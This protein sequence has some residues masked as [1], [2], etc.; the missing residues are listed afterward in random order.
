MVTFS[1]KG[2]TQLFSG[3]NHFLS[4]LRVGQPMKGQKAVD[5]V[6]CGPAR[7][8]PRVFLLPFVL[9]ATFVS[10]PSHLHVYAQT[11]EETHLYLCKLARN[12]RNVVVSGISTNQITLFNR[13][14]RKKQISWQFLPFL[15]LLTQA[16]DHSVTVFVFD[17]AGK[18][19]EE[20]LL[21]LGFLRRIR[22]HFSLGRYNNM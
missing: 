14:D 17:F 16:D 3:I 18:S 2:R 1:A 12:A 20:V 10:S 22:L 11:C 4:V 7:A 6:K 9:S 5:I 15:L 21:L 13:A 8:L 19:E